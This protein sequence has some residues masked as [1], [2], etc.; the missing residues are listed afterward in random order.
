MHLAIRFIISGLIGAFIGYT[1][2]YIAIRML[3]Y[4]QRMVCGWQGLLPRFKEN[5]A[6]KVADFVLQF[7]DYESI[8]EE[9]VNKKAFT[10]RVGK[11]NWGFLKTAIGYAVSTDIEHYLSN[12]EI[13][14][15]VAAKLT[16]MTPKAK[17]FLI[18]KIVESN[19]E[20]L[21]KLIMSY[22]GNEIRV[23]QRLGAFFGFVIGILSVLFF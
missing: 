10:T 6:D 8:L 13:R 19:T 20:K 22:S 18:K 17:A 2:N 9:I 21:T 11:A 23:V 14:K 15:Y 7:I 16:E 5:F 4:P 12:P 3:F 1:T